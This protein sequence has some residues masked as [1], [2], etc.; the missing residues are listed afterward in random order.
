MHS[1]MQVKL[2]LGNSRAVFRNFSSFF[3]TLVDGLQK[4]RQIVYMLHDSDD[5]VLAIAGGS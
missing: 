4:F 5:L 1:N 3:R 2:T